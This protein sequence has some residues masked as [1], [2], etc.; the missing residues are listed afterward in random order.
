MYWAVLFHLDIGRG[1]EGP[2]ISGRSSGGLLGRSVSQRNWS[3]AITGER[4][5]TT[6]AAG[7]SVAKRD[8][9]DP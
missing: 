2:G 9:A 3:G 5:K 1:S 7:T 4:I 8:S 6:N